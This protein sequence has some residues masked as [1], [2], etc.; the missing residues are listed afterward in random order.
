M[1][2]IDTEVDLVG[3]FSYFDLFYE[4][5]Q[6]LRLLGHGSVFQDESFLVTGTL[7]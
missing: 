5:R 4:L 2:F 1:L 6:E 3:L 7:V